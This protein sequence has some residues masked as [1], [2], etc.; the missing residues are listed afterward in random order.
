MTEPRDFETTVE[1]RL[2][3]YART[4]TRPFDA[5]AVAQRTRPTPAARWT[6]SSSMLLWLSVLLLLVAVVVT[7]LVV[8]AG[9]PGRTLFGPGPDV[10]R[11]GRGVVDAFDP[12]FE[13]TLPGG[14]YTE[15]R[16]P[17]A[18]E[19]WSSDESLGLL[20]WKD[21]QGF[22]DPCDETAGRYEIGSNPD[23]FVAYFERH[24]SF[25]VISA[26]EGSID[27]RRSVHLMLKAGTT[28]VCPSGVFAQW[29]PKADT[30]DRSW[31]LA[32]GGLDSLHLVEVDGHLVMLQVL[33]TGHADEAAVIE[34]VRFLGGSP[35]A[36]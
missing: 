5:V 19:I 3:A 10:L 28:A 2:Q 36:P 27:G 31:H 26:A 20:T 33:P 22:L 6:R 30:S 1:Q 23:A 16:T 11:V 7:G 24:P 13:V 18:I 12:T 17:D 4:A 29:Q 15:T 8:G 32:P 14:T 35:A 34:S 9:G 25:Q 21:P